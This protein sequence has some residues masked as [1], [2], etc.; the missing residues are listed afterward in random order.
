MYAISPPAGAQASTASSPARAERASSAAARSAPRL[1]NEP[2]TPAMIC[3]LP[4][5]TDRPL[6]PASG[7]LPQSNSAA[8]ALA[9]VRLR[10][11]PVIVKEAG[12]PRG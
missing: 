3:R 5:A 6:L 9:T 12:P 10:V 2:L 4:A 7:A 11:S 1:R 8:P